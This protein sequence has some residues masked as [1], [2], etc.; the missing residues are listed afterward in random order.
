MEDRITTARLRDI[1]GISPSYASMILNGKRPCPPEMAIKV[2]RQT[3]QRIG[4]LE[5]ATIEEIS[6]LE[7]FHGGGIDPLHAQTSTAAQHTPS[8]GKIATESPSSI[9][10]A[11]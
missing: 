8:P 4:P 7:K 1:A 2:Y 10:E 5:Q 3:G 9:G 11:A 6:V